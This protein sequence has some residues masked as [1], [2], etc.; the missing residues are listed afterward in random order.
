[1]REFIE[2]ILGN[3]RSFNADV[4]LGDEIS[5]LEWNSCGFD[6][7]NNLY[8]IQLSK[9]RS[10]NIPS[11][12]RVNQDKEPLELSDDEYLGEFNLLV[13]DPSLNIVSI[14]SNYFG[15]STKQIALTLSSLRMNYL[16]AIGESDGDVPH[17]VQLDPIIDNTAIDRVRQNEIY[18]KIVIKGADYREI[19]GDHL[20]SNTLSRAIDAIDEVHGVNF[21]LT[22][23]MS[24]SPK[25]ES[26]DSAEV[27]RMI[28]DVV[29]LRQHDESDVSMHISSRRDEE[30]SMEYL[31][32]FAPRLSSYITLVVENRATIGAEYLFNGFKEQNYYNED[33]AMQNRIGRIINRD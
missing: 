7:R 15:L 20:T 24:Q 12:K 6:E 1:M 3:P 31:D 19:A 11:R 32:L 33:S 29:N 21:E 14:Q 26:L 13:F 25:N 23:T 2:Y 10:K 17:V 18:R 28:E 22:V 5:D 16:E 4:F 27:R 8:Y 30:D 9:L